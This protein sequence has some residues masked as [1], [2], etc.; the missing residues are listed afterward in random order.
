[1]YHIRRDR[2]WHQLALS[3][4][5][6]PLG[7]GWLLAGAADVP[8]FPSPA[9]VPT[10]LVLQDALPELDA[11]SYAVFDVATSR[12]LAGHE[13]TTPRSIASI[14][15]L[16]A[17]AAL[18]AASVLDTPLTLTQADI[19]T[20]GTAGALTVGTPSTPRELL[21]PLLLT[22]S[23]DAAA[24][25][26]RT[27]DDLPHDMT[28]L[29]RRAGAYDTE[30]ADAS[31]LAAGNRS[32]AADLARLASYLYTSDSTLFALTALP[33]YLGATQGWQN[34]SPVI[35]FPGY[36]GGKHG[37]TEA[38]GRTI[39]ALFAEEVSG[40]EVRLGYVVLG[41]ADLAADVATL[42]TFVQQHARFE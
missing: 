11:A 20:H 16:P 24:A 21:Y 15:K 7:A 38:A 36:L 41:S 17:A 18:R 12:V 34:N 33:Q 8:M 27:V 4:G 5:L 9:I 25:L 26:E 39:V 29:A 14:T 42:R 28:R 40:Q 37:Y 13:V 22:S 31:G 23:N 2:R 3:V 30:F 35:E 10:E 19:D 6:L 32:T 1:M